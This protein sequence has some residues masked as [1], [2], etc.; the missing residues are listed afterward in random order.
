MRP[1]AMLRSCTRLGKQQPSCSEPGKTGCRL[2]CTRTPASVRKRAAAPRYTRSR[3]RLPG[4]SVAAA[5]EA[6]RAACSPPP[7]VRSRTVAQAATTGQEQQQG[8]GVCGAAARPSPGRIFSI[9]A[10]SHSLLHSGQAERVLSQR[11]MQSRWKT[12]PQQPHAMLRPGW[13]AS[14]VGFAC[15]QHAPERLMA[16]RV[17]LPT[18]SEPGQI[19]GSQCDT[20][21]APQAAPGPCK[22]AGAAGLARQQRRPRERQPGRHRRGGRAQRGAPGTRCWARTGCFGR[23]RRCLCRWPRTTSPPRS[24]F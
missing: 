18:A 2:A 13:S 3:R 24:T 4:R 11:W 9:L 6:H 14:P 15:A 12:C 16:R 23:W 8:G 17:L 22:T 1:L 7:P 20:R 10:N 5:G 19:P 21:L